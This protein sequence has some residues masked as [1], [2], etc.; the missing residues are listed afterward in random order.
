MSTKRRQFSEKFKV[1]VASEDIQGVKSLAEL[2]TEYKVHPAQISVNRCP[3]P[4]SIMTRGP[5]ISIVFK[6]P[7]IQ[8]IPFVATKHGSFKVIHQCHLFEH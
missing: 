1:K 2:A 5:C 6:W 7:E 8:S 4:C 3:E